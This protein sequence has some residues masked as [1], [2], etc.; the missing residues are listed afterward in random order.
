MMPRKRRRSATD[1]EIQKENHQRS[2]ASFGIILV[3]VGM[4]QIVAL[5][6]FLFQF[7]RLSRVC[8]CVCV[9]CV[10]AQ[11]VNWIRFC[12]IANKRAR[13]THS[14]SYYR[15]DSIKRS[16]HTITL[17]LTFR[18]IPLWFSHTFSSLF[19]IVVFVIIAFFF[20]CTMLV[21]IARWLESHIRKPFC[22]RN[23]KSS[24]SSNNMNC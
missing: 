24:I 20:F 8:V 15:L 13:Q 21:S 4:Q 22:N 2:I 6:T 18:H 7:V 11:I 14:V 17:T 3:R 23:S 16:K 1:R 19:Y 9:P 5:A 10:C 12:R